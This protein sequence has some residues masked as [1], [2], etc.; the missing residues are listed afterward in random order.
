ML[1]TE[2]AK[3]TATLENVEGSKPLF[4]YILGE[5]Y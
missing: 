2:E 4:L 1:G 3:A 5:Q